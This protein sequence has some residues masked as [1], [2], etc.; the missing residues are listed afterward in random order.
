MSITTNSPATT[1]QTPL[2]SA[3]GNVQSI[4]LLAVALTPAAV[5]ANTSAEQTFSVNGLQ[6]GDVINVDKPTVQAGLGIINCRAGANTLY[7]GFS[8][9]TAGSITPTAGEV[10]AV[11]VLRPIAQDV[12]NGLPAS[13]P[14]P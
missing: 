4:W 6:V 10:Y 8:N 1:V 12:T 2:Q 9:N 11:S 3:V 14:T 5:A 7:I 13:L